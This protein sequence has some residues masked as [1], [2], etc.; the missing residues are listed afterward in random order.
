M[1][2]T[3]PWLLVGL[4]NPG[5]KYA[6]NRHNVGFM[7]VDRLADDARIDVGRSKFK[8]VYGAGELEGHKLVCGEWAQE[9]K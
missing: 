1:S 3:A 5:P 8:G 4:G 7:V 6:M 9:K 2:D